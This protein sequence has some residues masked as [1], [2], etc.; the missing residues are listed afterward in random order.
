MIH[1]K[2]CGCVIEIIQVNER[3]RIKTITKII[4]ICK[5]HNKSTKIKPKR[6]K[7]K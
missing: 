7:K 4:K 6:E 5:L 3:T 1:R 2:P